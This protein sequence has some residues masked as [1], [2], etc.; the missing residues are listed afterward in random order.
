MIRGRPGPDTLADRLEAAAISLKMIAAKDPGAA[1]FLATMALRF[2]VDERA[3]SGALRSRATQ[4]TYDRIHSNSRP[5][6]DL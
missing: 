1:P 2:G 4:R 6:I 3:L 5:E